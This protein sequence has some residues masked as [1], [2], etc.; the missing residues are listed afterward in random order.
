MVGFIV[1]LFLKEMINVIFYK[2]T[3]WDKYGNKICFIT[4]R[5]ILMLI[6]V[7]L[8]AQC[9][10]SILSNKELLSK[11]N[12]DVAKVILTD[13]GGKYDMS[14][15]IYY[16]NLE[17]KDGSYEE[18]KAILDKDIK[19]MTEGVCN[20]YINKDDPSDIKVVVPKKKWIFKMIISLI[21]L[22]GLMTDI[23]LRVKKYILFK[24]RN[25][26]VRGGVKI[27]G[28]RS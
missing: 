12:T 10:L 26:I 9:R 15:N 3:L 1:L 6:S 2:E 16:F 7:Y 23:V 18:I 13:Y 20:I 27:N 11:Y 21:I 8:L 19:P 17:M 25:I 5:I 14:N 4:F 28:N 24:K 22:A